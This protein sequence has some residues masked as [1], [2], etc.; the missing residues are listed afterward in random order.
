MSESMTPTTVDRMRSLGIT[1]SFYVAHTY[2]WGDRHRDIFMGPERA[3]RMSPTA[4]ALELGLR[5]SIHLDTPVVP[6]DPM[7]LVWS[8]VNRV[9]TSGQIIGPNERISA[10][11]ALRAVT[12]DAAWQIH[13]EDNRGSIEAGKFADLV[14]LTENP[15]L[16]PSRI[17]DIAVDRTV[18]GGR[19]IYRRDP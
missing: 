12:I 7:L 13:Q 5:Y 9:S 8:A 11:A 19:T 10:I 18:V 1:P 15:A 3:S 16:H 2:Y 14:V 6:M 17:R 4:T